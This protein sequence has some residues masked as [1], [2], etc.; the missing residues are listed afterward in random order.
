MLVLASILLA[1]LMLVMLTLYIDAYARMHVQAD[2]N[3][4]RRF[5]KQLADEGSCRPCRFAS[6]RPS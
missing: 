3:E 6:A 1:N 2:R 4:G 5:S